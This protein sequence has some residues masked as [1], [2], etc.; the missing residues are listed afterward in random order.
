MW[1][2]AKLVAWGLLLL[3]IWPYIELKRKLLKK[4]HIDNCVTWAV[5]RWEEKPESYLCIR[6]CRSSRTDLKWPHFLWLEAPQ[7]PDMK[8]FIP[9]IDQQET[10]F[11]PDAFFEG[12]IVT[13]DSEEQLEN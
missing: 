2:F 10:K 3:V 12:K 7:N 13:G 8:H 4:P 11:I 9:L 5:R 1:S 6:W